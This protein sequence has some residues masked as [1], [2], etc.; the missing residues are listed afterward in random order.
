ML[1]RIENVLIKNILHR[2]AFATILSFSP[3]VYPGPGVLYKKN[4][5]KVNIPDNS[6]SVNSI[7]D[8]S[9]APSGAII[10]NVN[11]HYEI[12]HSYIGNLKV[13]LTT[14][15]D[16][17]WHDFILKDR[18]GGNAD[19]I[20]ETRENLTIWNG[21]STNQIWYLVVQDMATGDTGYVDSFEIWEMYFVDDPPSIPSSEDTNNGDMGISINPV[22]DWT[23]TDLNNDTL[24]QTVFF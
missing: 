12:R 20:I 24:F 6:V 1:F 19:S 3:I 14:F 5:C 23:C 13:W 9:D 8:L 11:I 15:Y 4:L 22:L 18:E 2:V 21:A 17:A 10:T 16:D 7:V